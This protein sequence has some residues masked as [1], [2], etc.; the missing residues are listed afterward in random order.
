MTAWLAGAA[1]VSLFGLWGYAAG[2]EWVSQAEGVRRVQAFYGSANNLAL[3]LDRT[4]Q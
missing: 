2:N 4:W 1:L 3:Y